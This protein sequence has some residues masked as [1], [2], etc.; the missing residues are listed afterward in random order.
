MHDVEI[1]NKRFLQ[2]LETEVQTG[3]E[4]ARKSKAALKQGTAAADNVEH[5]LATG[6]NNNKN[7]TAKPEPPQTKPSTNTLP[8]SKDQNI[9]ESN[10]SPTDSIPPASKT[11]KAKNRTADFGTSDPSPSEE[12]TSIVDPDTSKASTS[13][14]SIP[15]TNINLPEPETILEVPNT[16]L[17]TSTPAT[18][19][20]PKDTNTPKKSESFVKQKVKL[21]NRTHDLRKTIENIE[22]AKD[23]LRK[24]IKGETK[25]I[26]ALRQ[27]NKA[28]KKVEQ[29]L[30]KAN[31]A[32]LKCE[33]ELK[34]TKAAVKRID[35]I[36][37]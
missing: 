28:P 29:E 15:A 23:D 27:N 17:D 14:Q 22:V 7:K 24:R 5:I 12:T 18:D 26:A 35:G 20:H 8:F 10:S 6:Q 25:E 31:N 19:T 33:I 32:V 11:T 2:E 16:S 9:P 36:I 13:A 3:E 4:R 1:D 30:E 37:N 21:I 34:A